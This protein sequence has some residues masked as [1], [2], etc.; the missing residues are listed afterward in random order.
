[1]FTGQVH[2]KVFIQFGQVLIQLIVVPF[3][4]TNVLSLVAINLAWLSLQSAG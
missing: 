1:M 4:W 2:S 3:L